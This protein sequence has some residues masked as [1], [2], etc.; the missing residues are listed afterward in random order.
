MGLVASRV[1]QTLFGFSA[2]GA[3]LVVFTIWCVLLA[4]GGPLVMVREW[5]EKFGVWAVYLASAW[6][7]FYLVTK[8]DIGALLRQGGTGGMPFLLA[9]D[10]V[11]AM[12]ISWMPLVADYNRFSRESRGAFW[13]TYL[14]YLLSNIW[15]YG[16]GVLVILAPGVLPQ[17]ASGLTPEHLAAA[18]MAMRLGVVALAVIL[19]DET[20]NGFAD[21][22]SAAV[23]MQN[24]FPRVKQRYLVLGVGA[25]ALGLAAFLT[26][27]QFFGFLLLIGSIFVPLFGVL[28]ADYFVVRHRSYD[29]DQLYH[30]GGPYWYSG[31]FNFVGLIAWVGGILVYQIVPR[32]APNVGSTLPSLIFAF[33]L[34]WLLATLRPPG[35]ESTSAVGT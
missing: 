26:M 7:T 15:F 4:L 6:M 22:Y 31:G 21:I 9:V 12:P 20:D 33:G 25:A 10:L 23:S 13:G 29:V 24:I 30:P 34:Y 16:L 2:Y 14:G 3:W 11:I 17:E 27:G 35:T 1:T 19:V 8:S 18:I 32:I 28:I 5:L